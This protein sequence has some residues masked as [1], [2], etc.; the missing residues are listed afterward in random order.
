MKTPEVWQRGPVPDIHPLLQPVAHA[1]LQAR[2]EVEQMMSKFPAHLLWIRP[3][4][5]ASAGFHLQHMSGVIDRLFTYA[6][7]EKLNEK[8]FEYLQNEGKNNYPS[9]TVKDLVKHF[10]LQVDAALDQLK[11]TEASTLTEPRT[12]G[13]AALPSTVIGL[14]AHAA[15]HTMRHVGQMLVTTRMV[16]HQHLVWP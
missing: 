6:R 4:G 16:A 8:Q 13:R 15:E 5:L 12:V 3:E 9:Y 2:E 10:S 14:L 7:N 11:A 1:L